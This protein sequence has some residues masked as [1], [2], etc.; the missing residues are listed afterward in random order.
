MTYQNALRNIRSQRLKFGKNEDEH[1]GEQ[2]YTEN[3]RIIANKFIKNDKNCIDSLDWLVGKGEFY[4][5]VRDYKVICER[6]I[7]KINS[8]LRNVRKYE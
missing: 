5:Q 3:V 1:A 4:R 6:G 2:F 8:L 7:D